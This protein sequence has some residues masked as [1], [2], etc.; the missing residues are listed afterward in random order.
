MNEFILEHSDSVMGVISGFD[1][2]RFRGTVRLLAN[3]AGLDSFLRHMGVL[4]KDA[5]AWMEK[6]SESITKASLKMADNSGRPVQYINNSS[7]SKEE[8]ARRIAEK[9]RGLK[10]G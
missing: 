10:K 6:Q 1:R 7:Q 9:D 5:G 2:L 8:I 4:L 3:S